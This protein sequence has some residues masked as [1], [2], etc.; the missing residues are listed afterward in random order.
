MAKTP[1]TIR[2]TNEPLAK[3]LEDE[4]KRLIELGMSL[5][6]GF[7]VSVEFVA[8]VVGGTKDA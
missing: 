1:K 6:D 5:R 2:V 7:D 4:G 3:L 8:P